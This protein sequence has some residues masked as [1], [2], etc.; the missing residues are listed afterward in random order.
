LAP[1]V[2]LN[3]A[4]RDVKNCSF[5]V[6]ICDLEHLLQLEMPNWHFKFA[7]CSLLLP[8]HLGRDPAKR[9]AG[10]AVQRFLP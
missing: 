3:I 2:S 5:K 9:D 4:N 6:A 7:S 8:M 10:P 1:Q